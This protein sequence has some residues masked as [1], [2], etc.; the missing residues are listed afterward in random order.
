M[1]Q[2]CRYFIIADN[3]SELVLA[4]PEKTY[5]YIRCQCIFHGAQRRYHTEDNHCPLQFIPKSAGLY[6]G[7]QLLIT[8]DRIS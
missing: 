7:T 3:F 5:C 6:P 8:P 2:I 1:C 4:Y